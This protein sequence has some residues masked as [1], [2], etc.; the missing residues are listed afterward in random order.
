MWTCHHI[1]F[2]HHLI[3]VLFLQDLFFPLSGE[4]LSFLP[5]KCWQNLILISAVLW[6]WKQGYCVNYTVAL[7]YTQW[8]MPHYCLYPDPPTAHVHTHACDTSPVWYCFDI[9]ME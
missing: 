9:Q 4:L 5:S 8:E 6:Q 2:I 3:G 7:E 1:H